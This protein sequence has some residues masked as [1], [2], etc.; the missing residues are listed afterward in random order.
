MPGTILRADAAVLGTSLVRHAEVLI[1][2]G[3]I[4]AAGPAAT[5]PADGSERVE[6]VEGV[7][8]PGPI[9]LQVNGAGG[10]SVDEAS[11]P[12]LDAVAAAVRAGGATAFL[13]TLITA[14]MET[15]C[16]RLA[17]LA[18]WIEGPRRDGATPLGIHLEGPFL[19][20]AGAH[21]PELCLDP[22]P[23]RV[24][25]LLEAA[26]GHLALVTLAPGRAGAAE[27]TRRFVGAGVR[28]ALGHASDA[29]GLEDCVDAGATL[30][31]HLF[32]AMGP[33]H[34]RDPGFAGMALDESR[35]ACSLIVDGVHVHPAMLR[36]AWRCLGAERTVLVTD[37]VSAAGMPDGE[38]A[39]A[40]ET[41]RLAD[42]VVRDAAGR[43]AGSALRC[44]DAA[45]LF[46]ATVPG[47]GPVELAAVLSRNPA[48][49]LGDGERGAIAAGRLAE[50][51]VLGRDGELRVL[52]TG[53]T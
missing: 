51:A 14:P 11:A 49:L 4:R 31:T 33:V 23:E 22:A 9:D 32:N 41:V 47:A 50:L 20:L 48:R 19:E 42:G 3:R 6:R 34:H 7:L 29:R 10:H 36:V 30:V 25:A 27:A 37:S 16:D 17:A 53:A 52:E 8:L 18:D 28:V 44:S 40:G 21:R 43:L 35:L 38:Y 45:R 2:A 5:V 46:L 24:E 1:E 39:L 26:R 15:L 13:P 12:A